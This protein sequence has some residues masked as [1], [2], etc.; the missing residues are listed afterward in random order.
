MLRRLEKRILVPL[1]NSE[2]RARMFASLLAGRCAAGV[3][4]RDLATATEGYSGSDVTLVAK[5]AAMRPLRRLMTRLEATPVG[6]G[7]WTRGCCAAAN[8]CRQTCKI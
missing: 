6:P 7:E 3:E 5:E 8:R 1:P 4:P 2:A